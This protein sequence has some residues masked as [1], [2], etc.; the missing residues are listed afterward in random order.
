MPDEQEIPE[1][2]AAPEVE[3]GTAPES[4]TEGQ[5]EPQEGDPKPKGGFQKRI[6]KLTKNNSELER[7]KEFWRQEALRAKTPVV[8][9]P[10]ASTTSEL[11][12]PSESDFQTHSEY[13][14]ALTKYEVAIAKEELVSSQRKSEAQTRTQTVQQEFK[15]RQEAF[16][17]AT[18]DFDE[19]LEEADTRV[20]ND[21]IQEIVES[22]HGPELQ[23]YLAKNPDEALRLSSLPPLKLAREVGKIESRFSTTQESTPAKKTTGAPPP[24]TPT[25]KSS[26]T[27]GKDPG[28]MNPQ[29]YRA[30][31][32]KQAAK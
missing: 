27:S 28:D 3:G 7:E 25:G 19:V 15:A 6:D 30:W 29:E 23:Y 17:A 21:L 26:P 2:E 31:F 5:Q 9:T 24:P 8:E 20:S 13:V 11:K 10:K 1:Q 18:P 16:R 22:E 32:A 4:A 12:E 14:R